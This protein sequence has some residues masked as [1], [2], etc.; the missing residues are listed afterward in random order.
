MAI[1]NHGHLFRLIGSR[2]FACSIRCHCLTLHHFVCFIQIHR[3][4]SF[5]LILSHFSVY[6]YPTQLGW[7]LDHP[8]EHEIWCGWRR[9]LPQCLLAPRLSRLLLVFLPNRLF[10]SEPKT[11]DFSW[12]CDYFWQY[13]RYPVKFDSFT[14]FHQFMILRRRIAQW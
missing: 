8:F 7:C 9:Y 1:V 3:S 5:Y 2:L 6:L 11:S 14:I 10:L 12:I 13:L 4:F